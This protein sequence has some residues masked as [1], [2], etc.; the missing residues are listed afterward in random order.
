M[1]GWIE[2]TMTKHMQRMHSDIELDVFD[3][4][5][6]G[7][8]CRATPLTPLLTKLTLAFDV[9]GSSQ[10]ATIRGMCCISKLLNLKTW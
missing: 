3:H 10:G 5:D 8:T 6:R 7:A 2:S 4:S 9:S 1:H